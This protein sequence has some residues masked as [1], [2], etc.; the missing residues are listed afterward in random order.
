MKIGEWPGYLSNL[1]T[2]PNR[3]IGITPE[4]YVT[5]FEYLN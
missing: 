5:K 1:T 3:S 4:H 2:S